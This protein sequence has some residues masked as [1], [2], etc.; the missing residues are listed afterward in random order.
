[1]RA[2]GARPAGGRAA[3]ARRAGLV[4]GLV[5]AA[6][7]AGA[8]CPAQAADPP[9]RVPVLYS[10][11]LFHPHD[12]PDD[13]FDLAALYG[14]EEI[15]LRGIVL[16]QGARQERQPGRVAVEQLNRLTGRAVPWATGLAEALQSPDDPALEQAAAHQGGVALILEA[17]ASSPEPLTI[18]TV[19]SLRDVAA[20]LN[21][22]PERFRQKVARLLVFLGAT[23]PEV[24]EWNVNLD[25]NAWIRVM[26]SGLPIFWVPCFDGGM[27]V[28]KG[29][30]SFWRAPHAE[31]LRHASDR[32]MQF[33]LYALLKKS[34]PDPVAFLG[35]AVDPAERAQVLAG[36]RNLWCAAIFTHVAGRRIVRAADGWHSAPRGAVLPA[37]AEEVAAFRFVPVSLRVDDDARVVYE[38]SPQ[39]H[40]V[41]RFQV[42]DRE[43]YGAVMTAVTSRLIG[44]VREQQP[45]PAARPRIRNPVLR[46]FRPDPS[47]VRVGEDFYIATSTFEWFPGVEIHHSRDLV[48]WRLLGHALERTQQIDLRGTPC[49]AGVWAPDLTWRDGTFYLV[50]THVRSARGGFVD[51]HNYL[52]TAPALPGPWAEPIY[53]NSSGFD[54]ALF[55]DDDGR[56]YLLNMLWDHRARTKSGGIVLQE[57]D[58]QAQRL[59]GAPRVIFRGTDA[60]GTEAPHLYRHGGYYHLMTAE[61]GTWYEHGVTMARARTLEGPYLPDPGNPILTSR[62]DPTLALQKAG[63]A[64]LVSAPGGELYLAFLCARP[65][66]GTRLCNLGRETALRRCAWSEAGW[67]RLAG[68][69]RHPVLEEEAPALP[70][71]PFAAPPAREE[72][73]GSALPAAFQTPRRPPEE[74]GCSL[75]ERPGWLRL[76][77]R[78]SLNSEFEV[79]LVAR[80]VEAFG[81]EATTRL[82][83]APQSFQ[84]MAGL[85]CFYDNRNYR[86]LRVSHDEELGR[87]VA[88]LSLD[89][90]TLTITEPV[91]LDPGA[92][93]YLRARFEGPSL[94]FH[95]STDGRDWRQ[96]GPV[97]EAG[98]LSDDHC[99]GFTGTFVGLAAQDATGARRQA[100]F[101]FLECRELR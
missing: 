42:V 13:H 52:V 98:R 75:A 81:W 69:G 100:D 54:P 88:V 20:A 7:I 66:P 35:R 18:I 91:A 89:R 90:G 94:T 71:H 74:S 31:L 32:M 72:F 96:V 19:G 84:Q 67:L 8:W 76:R 58:R 27:F 80:R 10:T 64:S 17:L 26:N 78:E 16:D 92:A 21:R 61:G 85:V 68:G 36:T 99:R 2:G 25:P 57:Y 45:A 48:H 83:F 39:T 29:N 12:D 24:R 97:L 55:H 56:T 95:H 93:C 49:S 28:N 9:P 47:I 33:F 79:S 65:L 34:E 63:H 86:Y 41:Q 14:L 40:R 60:G 59:I 1:M 50:Y 5:L 37:G 77:G 6:G 23:D 82:E 44:S 30:A 70:S 53:L 101:D 22:E 73:D 62:D 3:G 38:E 11:D 46:G 43:R 87:N 51:A 4:V 15:E